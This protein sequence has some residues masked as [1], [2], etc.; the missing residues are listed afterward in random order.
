MHL[1]NESSAVLLLQLHVVIFFLPC[2]ILGNL[3]VAYLY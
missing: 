1:G 3:V 2:S